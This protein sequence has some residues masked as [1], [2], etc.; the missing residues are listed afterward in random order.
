MFVHIRVQDVINVAPSKFGMD[1]K[2]AITDRIG[3]KYVGKIMPKPVS[4]L[5]ISLFELEKVGDKE[6]NAGY[7]FP[8]DGQTFFGDIS[9]KVTF[10]LV[11]FRPKLN[12]LFTGKVVR[13]DHSGVFVNI[14]FAEIH[15]LPVLMMPPS[16]F[17]QGTF[18]A[19]QI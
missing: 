2:A 15:V 12:E 14:G 5:V 16:V 7:I 11:V 3:D 1:Y 19:H 13:S 6:S 18:F 17:D 10:T 9:Y 4:G 8:G